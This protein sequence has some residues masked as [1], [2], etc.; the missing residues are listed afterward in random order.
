MKN[1]TA[2]IP[3]YALAS[4]IIYG[5]NWA[6]ILATLTVQGATPAATVPPPPATG[7]IDYFDYTFDYAKILNAKSLSGGLITVD[8]YDNFK[9][10]ATSQGNFYWTGGSLGIV[11]FTANYQSI[12][13][14]LLQIPLQQPVEFFVPAIPLVEVGQANQ[15]SLD[16][17][18]PLNPVG[19]I[20][21]SNKGTPIFCEAGGL[22]TINGFP[23]AAAGS[24]VGIFTL[25]DAQTLARIY[26]ANPKQPAP[27]AAAIPAII[28]AGFVDNGNGTATLDPKVLKNNYGD[29]KIVY[30]YKENGSPCQSF[31]SQIIRISPNPIGQFTFATVIG[32]N[33]PV[34]TALCS[35]QQINFDASTSTVND[36]SATL[37]TYAWT[38]GDPNSATNV[39]TTKTP[40]HIFDVFGSYITNMVVS[41]NWK[42]ASVPLAQTVK[43]GEKPVVKFAFTGVSTSDSFTF[44][45]SST[46][47]TN[48]ALAKLDW[49]YGDGGIQSVTSG[50]TSP[51]SHNYVNPGLASVSLKV[52]SVIGCANSAST[53][54]VVLPKSTLS[55]LVVYNENFE[56]SNANWQIYVTGNSA[57]GLSTVTPTWAYGK[58]T[59]SLSTTGNSTKIWK[60]NLAGNYRGN[61]RSALYSPSF[62]LTQLKRPMISLDKFVQMESSDGVVLQYSTD[63]LNI[64]DVNKVWKV[65]GQV[66]DGVEWFTDQGLAAKPG[67]QTT[68]DYGWSGSSS[69][70]WQAAKH[71]LA[72]IK[73]DP[74]G[75]TKVVF[76]FALASAK[77]APLF[78]G[79]ALDNVRIGE[80]TRT[81][82]LESFTNTASSSKD[83]R[84]ENDFIREFNKAQVG[85]EVVKIN[86]HVSFPSDDP[87]NVDNAADPSSRALFYSINSTP[88]SR[89][90]GAT[91][92][93]LFSVWGDPT[94][95]V[96]S[97]QLAQAAMTLSTTVNNGVLSI[98]IGV[99]AN[100][101]LPANTI[102][103]VAALEQSIPLSGLSTTQKTQVKTNE[104][105]FDYVLKRLLP[106]AAG[107]PFGQ[108]LAATKSKTF[109]PFTWAPDSK[110]LYPAANDL[111]I[112]A[113][114]QNEITGAI[115]QAELLSNVSDP[116]VVTGLE[117]ISADQIVVYPNPA[118]HEMH[119]LLPG[120]LRQSA[121]LKLIDATG[122]TSVESSIPEGANSRTV[123]T[124][125]LSPGIYILQIDIGNGNIT[126]K[127]V[128][129]VHEQ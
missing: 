104:T 99:T 117:P 16:I 6:N 128:M 96:G 2:A 67:D 36:P 83:E 1:I 121:G 109:G 25:I 107:T 129:V 33:T 24:S 88:K 105:N 112:A 81:V 5:T 89:L 58:A 56:T 10:S 60:T 54:I 47:A 51:A 119:I 126:R 13:N 21:A 78:E 122:R 124:S 64:V 40:N 46:V 62:D 110:R 55:P 31:S 66:G 28:P 115:Y 106:S 12:A 97:L 15:S 39:G 3:L 92:D 116:P 80:R 125:D 35:K 108:V 73:N 42:C 82:L 74:N 93:G 29:I 84:S 22:I 79:F 114:L 14:A 45:S 57:N 90:D 95:A 19:S 4:Q 68:K 18:D 48:D 85:T 8:P 9:S 61:E 26:E 111:V 72:D 41:S 23:A 27:P 44:T 127:K 77:A 86:Y 52:T 50:F 76:R 70:A 65:L 75:L 103:Q 100:I 120:Q 101:D 30:T 34:A 17:L 91:K 87:F 94:F 102:L 11:E 53:T 49:T 63:G 118:N 43:V 59:T 38:F 20:S 71:T 113:F 37:T 69:T 7:G 32:A 123:G 98:S